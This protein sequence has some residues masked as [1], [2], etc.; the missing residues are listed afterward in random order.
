[1]QQRPLRRDVLTFWDYPEKNRTAGTPAT[2]NL[3]LKAIKG[4]CER[5]VHP[6]ALET[7]VGSKTYKV[8]TEDEVWPLEEMLKNWKIAA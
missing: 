6:P 8:R 1:M 7:P 4:I 2:G 5:F 3:P